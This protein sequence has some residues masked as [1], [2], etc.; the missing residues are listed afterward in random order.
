[1]SFSAAWQQVTCKRCRR[2]YQCTPA[3]DY[4]ALPG[5]E[6]TGPGDGQCFACMLTA[7]GMD[8]ET[9]PVRV[10]DAGLRAVDPRDGR[11]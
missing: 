3:D 1:M 9:T 10:L 7:R 11:G 6:V 8:P 2:Q 5:E 4:W